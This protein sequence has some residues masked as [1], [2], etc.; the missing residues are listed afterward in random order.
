MNRLVKALQKRVPFHDM[1]DDLAS[2]ETDLL[3]DELAP[4]LRCLIDERIEDRIARA[5]SPAF[6]LD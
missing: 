2:W 4:A 1:V 3:A 6:Q 5:G